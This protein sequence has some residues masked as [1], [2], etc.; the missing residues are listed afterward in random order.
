MVMTP[1]DLLE[2]VLKHLAPRQ[3]DVF[4]ADELAGRF[5]VNVS[6]VKPILDE[7]EQCGLVYRKGKEY[8]VPQRG[9][10]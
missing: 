7:L 9:E 10:K 6:R 8:R 4:T 2:S 1:D 5:Q 3:G